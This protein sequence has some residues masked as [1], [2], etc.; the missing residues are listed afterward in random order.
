MKKIKLLFLGFFLFCI[1]NSGFSQSFTSVPLNNE[2]YYII[3]NAVLR[4]L[5]KTPPSA[6][7][8]SETTV[9]ELLNDIL[10]S[11]KLSSAEYEV[12]YDALAQFERNPGFDWKK[13][14]FYTEKTLKDASKLSI[15]IGAT[16]DSFASFNLLSPFAVGNYNI[17]GGYIS[18]DLGKSLSYNFTG[19]GEIL[20]IPLEEYPQYWNDDSNPTPTGDL[21]DSSYYLPEFSPYSFSKVWEASI[22]KPGELHN[23]QSWPNTL[24]FGYEVISEIDASF[25]ENRV[26]LRFGRMRRDW[27]SNGVGNNLFMNSTARPYIGIEGTA[28]PADWISFSFITGVLEYYKV[29]S[30]KGDAWNFQNAFSVAMLEL[31]Y[32]NYFH[33]DGGSTTVW[34]KR[35]ELG[36]L[37][38]INSNF[39]YQNNVGD[40]DNL[41]I[42]FNISGQYPGIIK[43]WA[44]GF[45]DE[46]SLTSSPFFHLDR[47]MYAYQFGTKVNLPWIPFATVSLRYTKIEPYCYTH[48]TTDTPWYDTADHD[49]QEAYLNHG[50]NLG[51]YLPPNSDEICLR[52]ESMFK[53]GV[54]AYFQYQMI[55]HGTEYG[56]GRVFGS[57]FTDMLDYG[58]LDGQHKYFLHDGTYEW[59]HIIKLG[60]RYNLKSLGVP[61]AVYG[62]LGLVFVRYSGIEGG[63]ASES[64]ESYNFISNEYYE[65]QNRLIASIGIKIYPNTGR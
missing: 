34:P 19:R 2:V 62:E 1:L 64:K 46:M 23:Y 7:P 15:E 43:V 53:P 6:K 47:N 57:A 42:F 41:G 52:V 56:P 54:S 30:L 50:E 26:Q 5:C 22:F 63:G 16:W 38:P 28:I 48:P 4:G 61:M 9:K 44:S 37:F 21:S 12:I 8:W 33:I 59:N 17:L 39:L 35:F 51:Y 10:T 11:S 32:K 65:S 13:G 14:A 25:V 58:N 20:Y 31:N 24:S 60:G 29:T 45:I 27:G 40:F 36:Y 3:D 49:M 18:G 55:R